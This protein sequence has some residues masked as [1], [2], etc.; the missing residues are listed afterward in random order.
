MTECTSCGAE[1]WWATTEGGK[2]MPIDIIPHPMGPMVVVEQPAGFAG[3]PSVR[4]VTAANPPPPD[5][6]RFM[7][8]HVTCPQSKKWRMG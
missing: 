8:H 3:N 2:S 1:I 6:A 7:P 4:R 5:V